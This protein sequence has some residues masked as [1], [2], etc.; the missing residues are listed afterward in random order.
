MEEDEGVCLNAHSSPTK[1]LLRNVFQAASHNDHK[2][3]LYISTK[4]G[5]S[6]ITMETD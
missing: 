2:V 4:Y 3:P 6:I 1:N 5:I